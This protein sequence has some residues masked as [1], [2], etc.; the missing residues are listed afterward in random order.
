MSFAKKII[1]MFL[2]VVESNIACAMTYQNVEIREGCNISND[3]TIGEYTYIGINTTVTR[4]S[5][6]RYCSI[7]N[8]VSI[9]DGEHSLGR[10][11]TSAFFYENPYD[12]LTRK[13]CSIGNDVWI[14]TKSIIRRGVVIGNGA[15]VGANSFVN[16]DVP[17]FAVVVGSPAKVV[18]FR[19]TEQE[20]ALINDSNWWDMGLDEAKNEIATLEKKISMLRSCHS[21]KVP[22]LKL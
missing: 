8:N 5:I 13:G 3:C 2:P 7:A 11:S 4:S 6:G 19:F 22:E 9:G 16:R 15:V 10:I 20:I 21:H 12:E 14:G 17:A 1:R 18:K